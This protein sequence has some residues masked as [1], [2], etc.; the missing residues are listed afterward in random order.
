MAL[1][2]ADNRFA[3]YCFLPDKG[4]DALVE[5]LKK[6]SWS[7]LCGTLHPT[8]GSVDL[9]KFK[10]DTASVSIKH[11]ADLAWESPLTQVEPNLPG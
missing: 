4:V 8:D 1:P 11:S 6:S 3:M 9:P 10:V 2:Y 7:A 5:E